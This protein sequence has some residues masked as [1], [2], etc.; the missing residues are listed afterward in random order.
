MWDWGNLVMSLP[1]NARRH[2]TATEIDVSIG[3]PTGQTV[4]IGSKAKKG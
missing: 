4:R 1:D 3:E 2:F